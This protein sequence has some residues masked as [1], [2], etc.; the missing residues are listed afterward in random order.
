M[1]LDTDGVN[2][3]TASFVFGLDAVERVYDIRVLQYETNNVMGGP[4]GCLQFFVGEASAAGEGFPATVSGGN[5]LSFN[6]AANAG[7][8]NQRSSLNQVSIF[9]NK[10]CMFLIFSYS[11][12]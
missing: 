1:V 2:C 4:P 3:V 11:L 12:D 7:G 8:K 9:L 10:F 6:F 5:V